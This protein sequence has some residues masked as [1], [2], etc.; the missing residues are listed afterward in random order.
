MNVKVKRRNFLKTLI[1]T[2]FFLINFPICILY[3]RNNSLDFIFCSLILPLIFSYTEQDDE[4]IKL[5]NI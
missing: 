2:R 1:Y 3:I 5:F 4:N